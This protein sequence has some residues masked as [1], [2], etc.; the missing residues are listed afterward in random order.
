MAT[1]LGGVA[2]S[3]FL[4]KLRSIRASNAVTAFSEWHASAMGHR[5]LGLKLD[6]LIPDEGPIVQE[7]VRRLPPAEQQERLFRYRRAY[8]L[9]T[10]QSLLEPA[11]QLPTSQDTPYLTPLIEL[12]EAEVATKENFDL[13]SKIPENLK[14]RNRS[15]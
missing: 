10:I 12:V 15:S 5:A 13:L 6:D 14:R 8:Q 4:A 2:G 1:S 3:S 9:S 7:A 11:D